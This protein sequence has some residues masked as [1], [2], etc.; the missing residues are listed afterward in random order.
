MANIDIKYFTSSNVNAPQLNN[1]W[2][3]MIDVLD[4]CL[5]NGFG[6]QTASSIVVSNKV[7]TVTFS[8][9]HG[10]KQFQVIEISNS[11]VVDLNNQFKILGITDTTLTFNV[12]TPNNEVTGSISVKLASLGWEKTYTGT[13]KAVYRAKD[14]VT[15]PYYFRVDNSVDPVYNATFAKFAK[16]GYLESC[17]GIDDISGV[18][19]PYDSSNPTKNW[20]GIQNGGGNG[21]ISGWFKWQYACN[22]NIATA[23]NWYESEDIQ[24]GNRPWVIIGD[25]TSFYLINKL[26]NT[27]YMVS[28]YGFGIVN[29][30]SGSK[31]FLVAANKHTPANQSLNS[32]TSLGLTDLVQVAGLKDVAN[33]TSNSSFY[34]IITHYRT[35][36]S[37][38]LN[39]D[40]IL[41]TTNSSD[42]LLSPMILLDN[43]KYIL[44]E[45]PLIKSCVNRAETVSNLSLHNSNK[46]YYLATTFRSFP[47]G[48]I[49]NLF[50]KV[51]EEE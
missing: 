22:E 43:N 44:N 3:C 47:G 24:E 25:N 16:V 10:Y 12:N 51:Y 11:S 28:P 9:P 21:A 26:T 40:N 29:H 6:T 14:K 34:S 20:V 13:Q 1:T 37:G 50:F 17:T 5:I 18:Q 15:N 32:K 33:T 19:S 8:S 42:L 48:T 45:L 30:E 4:A 35:S 2:G 38:S 27:S 36:T 31:P 49:G 23:D 7:A 41:K 46:A 39:N